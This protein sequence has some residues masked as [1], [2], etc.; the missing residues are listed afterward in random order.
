[1]PPV[2]NTL[3]PARCAAI[4]VAATVV[5]PVRP[6]ATAKAKIGARQLHGAGVCASA[7]RSASRQADLQ[8]AVDDGDRRRHRAFLA[9]DLLDVRRH[10]GCCRDKAC[11]G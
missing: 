8:P 5:P 10:H 11:H 7:S 9:D 4:I 6:S 3:M 2:A 1:M